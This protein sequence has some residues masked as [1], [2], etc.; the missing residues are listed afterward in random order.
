VRYSNRKKEEEEEVRV[1][2]DEGERV[3]LEFWRQHEQDEQGVE[4]KD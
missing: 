1:E 2:A 3:W 4:K